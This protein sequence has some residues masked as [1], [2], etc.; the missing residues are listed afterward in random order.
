MELLIKRKK[1]NYELFI[2]IILILFTIILFLI[3]LS[4]IIFLIAA[5]LMGYADYMIFL[6]LDVEYE[7]LYINQELSIDKIMSKTKRKTLITMDVHKIG[8]LVPLSSPE[9]NA[10]KNRNLKKLDFSS[11]DKEASSYVII[12]NDEREQKFIIF[13]PNEKLLSYLKSFVR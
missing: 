12:Y 13:E 6:N 1:N 4:N 10:Y 3:G 9:L 8:L 5:A 2:K 11:G 7:Y